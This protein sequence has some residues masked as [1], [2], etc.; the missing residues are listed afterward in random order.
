MLQGFLPRLF[1]DGQTMLCGL[2]VDG[3]EP[4]R[5]VLDE[6]PVSCAVRFPGSGRLPELTAMILR[7]SSL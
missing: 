4:L 2:F 3:A 6:R 7:F 1:G 5:V